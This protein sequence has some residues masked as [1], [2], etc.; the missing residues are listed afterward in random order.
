MNADSQHDPAE[1]PRLLATLTD[2][3]DMPISTQG[4]GTQADC[5]L[6]WLV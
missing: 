4:R 2:G 3:Y 6:S 5:N 1:I